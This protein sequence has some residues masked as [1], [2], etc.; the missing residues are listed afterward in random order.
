VTKDATVEV[1][2]A[3]VTAVH[4]GDFHLSAHL[5]DL[6]QALWFE[7]APGQ[8]ARVRLWVPCTDT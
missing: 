8:D 3:A 4:D 6:L 5:A 1:F 2:I 7:S